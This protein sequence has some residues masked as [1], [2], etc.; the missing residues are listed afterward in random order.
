[1]ARVFRLVHRRTTAS[2]SLPG[3]AELAGEAVAG[4]AGQDPHHHLAALVARGVDH[5]VRDLVLGAVAAVARHQVH[6]VR[7]GGQRL[8]AGVAVLVGDADVPLDAVLAEHVVE[9]VE[10][11][12]VLPG[13]RVDHHVHPRVRRI[14]HDV[15]LGTFRARPCVGGPQHDDM[16]D[17]GRAAAHDR[18]AS[19]GPGGS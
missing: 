11:R 15:L 19:G 1:M 14:C 9:R 8:L 10:D 7:D 6:A 12:L 16:H 18:G 3:T 5:G 4:A 13:G 17:D 2:R